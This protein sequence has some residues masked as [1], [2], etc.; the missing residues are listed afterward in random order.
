M[1]FHSCCECFYYSCSASSQVL[2]YHQPFNFSHSGGGAVVFFPFDLYCLYL[3]MITLLVIQATIFLFHGLFYPKI[4]R[5]VILVRS[6]FPSAWRISFRISFRSARHISSQDLPEKCLDFTSLCTD[7]FLFFGFF[8]FAFYRFF[9]GVQKFWVD[10]LC[11]AFIAT[12]EN[13]AVSPTIA[14]LKG[15]CPFSECF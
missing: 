11:L 2:G 6:H 15:T 9:G 1:N 4:K 8:F 3:N 14:A 5:A 7:V 10:R 13:S 12:I